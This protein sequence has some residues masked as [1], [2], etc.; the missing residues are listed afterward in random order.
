MKTPPGTAALA[1]SLTLLASA[2]SPSSATAGTGGTIE[3]DRPI[4]SHTL[5]RAIAYRTYRPAAS[6]AA[7]RKLP[8]LYLLHGRGDDENAWI[9]KGGIGQVLD[10][11]IAAGKLKPL[12]VVM[13][14]A[15]NS[16]YVDDMMPDRFGDMSK[17]LTTDLVDG[18]EARYHV[19]RCRQARAVGGLSMGGYGAML[20]ALDRPDLFASVFSLS[21]SLFSEAPDD[22]ERRKPAYERIYGGVFGRPFDEKR[23]LAWNVF[24]RLDRPS[25]R[26]QPLAIWLAAGD[27][28]FPS[29]LD[30]TV[31]LHNEL[32]K[33]SIPS[34]L[35]IMKGEHTWELWNAAVEPAL[36]WLSGHLASECPAPSGK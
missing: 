11:A 12:I 10:R 25:L 4:E 17:A 15:G 26:A 23:F 34:E 1:A 22:I 28:D 35:H 18:I 32:G 3:V 2:L 9:E 33:R 13:P 16:W 8:V 14:A 29:I 27:R 36:E 5:G 30:G 24:M 20:Y 19:A 31:R 21:G 7:G 6:A